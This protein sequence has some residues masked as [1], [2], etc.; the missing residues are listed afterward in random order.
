MKQVKF[1][2]LDVA[3]SD[4]A[5]HGKNINTHKRT[6]REPLLT[7]PFPD[8]LSEDQ[9]ATEIFLRRLSISLANKVLFICNKFDH[10]AQQTIRNLKDQID[11][12]RLYVIHNL[13]EVNSQELLEHRQDELV[14]IYDQEA[15]DIMPLEMANGAV[16]FQTKL[17][18]HIFLVNDDCE[19]GK[20]HNELM[21]NALRDS[22]NAADTSKKIDFFAD[23][24]RNAQ[25]LLGE[26]H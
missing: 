23:F 11:D 8:V 22:L 2:L 3:G 24:Q 5:V 1:I 9:R 15:N 13:V 6:T 21:L 14:R 26:F 12:D 10:T 19:F 16:F 17:Y 7:N 25:K 20:A 4:V 18:N